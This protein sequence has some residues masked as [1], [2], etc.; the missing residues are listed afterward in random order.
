[1]KVQEPNI[2]C[3]TSFGKKKGVKGKEKM[4]REGKTI[5]YRQQ[6]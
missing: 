2:E 5:A 3:L 1:V 6:A 4:K